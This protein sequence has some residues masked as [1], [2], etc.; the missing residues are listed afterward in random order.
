M[1]K[2]VATKSRAQAE[3]YFLRNAAH[4]Y[5]FMKRSQDRLARRIV[6]RRADA[7][8]FP[9]APCT[10]LSC[11]RQGEAV[12]PANVRPG[13][14]LPANLEMGGSREDTPNLFRGGR[15]IPIPAPAGGG[16]FYRELGPIGAWR[17]AESVGE[18]SRRS[19]DDDIIIDKAGI[20]DDCLLGCNG[21]SARKRREC[22]QHPVWTRV[23]Y[24]V[25]PTSS[26]SWNVPAR[27]P[28]SG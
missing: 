13:A 7:A 5:K 23:K 12:E 17:R 28:P 4:V 25:S 21:G 18:S 14:V 11:A 2:F 9:R 10:V 16:E 15:L 6:A 3:K 24:H 27:W 22:C 26:S 19:T 8:G 20:R 1:K